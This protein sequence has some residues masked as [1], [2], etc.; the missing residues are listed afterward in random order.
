MKIPFLILFILIVLSGCKQVNTQATIKPADVTT[1]TLKRP[2]PLTE[3]YHKS[4]KPF[5]SLNIQAPI[6]A[7]LSIGKP[8]SLSFKTDKVHAKNLLTTVK[9]H[10]LLIT[11]ASTSKPLS[12]NS[13]S[14]TLTMPRLSNLTVASRA[15]VFLAGLKAQNLKLSLT[16]DAH[17]VIEG[18]INTLTAH[19]NDNALL[20]AETLTVH[21]LKASF[22]N[23]ANIIINATQNAYLRVNDNARLNIKGN[24]KD[25]SLRADASANVDGHKLNATTARVV[26]SDNSKLSLGHIQTLKLIASDSSKVSYTGRAKVTD[27]TTF[28]S[29]QVVSLNN[30]THTV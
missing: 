9:N 19:V 29:A 18:N 25:L 8:F 2:A 20:N 23:N 28:N 21:T 4:V 22:S 1:P 24:L 27:V 30:Y 16:N 12:T 5:T 6:N 14:M 26:A 3:T 13:V 11:L 7:T 15:R 17:M 10:V